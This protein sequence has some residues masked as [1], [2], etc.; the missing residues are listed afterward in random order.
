MPCKK[1]VLN[2][3]DDYN[4]DYSYDD[5][6]TNYDNVEIKFEA[7]QNVNK[8]KKQKSAMYA[9]EQRMKTHV[10]RYEKRFNK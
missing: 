3:N 9:N 2:N 10:K 7:Q 8:I 1:P 5:Y 4:S 6:D